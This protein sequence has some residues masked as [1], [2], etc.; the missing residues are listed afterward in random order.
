M[1]TNSAGLVMLVM[2]FFLAAGLLAHAGR[3]H[4]V[5]DLL[6]AL[7]AA[8]LAGGWVGAQF[9][10]IDASKTW[11]RRAVGVI[12]LLASINILADVIL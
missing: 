1:I 2:L 4:L 12:L 7:A 8:V 3:G 11:I 6:L 5:M 9:G 10:S